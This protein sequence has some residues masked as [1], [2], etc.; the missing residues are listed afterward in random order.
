MIQFNV[1]LLLE[2]KID[3]FFEEA[4]CT[5]NEAKGLHYHHEIEML[6]EVS[7]ILHADY[8]VKGWCQRTDLQSLHCRFVQITHWVYFRTVYYWYT[9]IWYQLSN[10]FFHFRS[11]EIGLEGILLMI[12]KNSPLKVLIESRIY[13]RTE[14][15]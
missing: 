9:M 1:P 7:H 10:D 12:P 8:F 3:T 4:A 11:N 2:K 14:I 5:V 6:E 13:K 15:K